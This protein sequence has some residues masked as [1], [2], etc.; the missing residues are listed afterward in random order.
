LK[1]PGVIQLPFAE[2]IFGVS[3]EEE[4]GFTRPNKTWCVSLTGLIAL[5]TISLI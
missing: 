5:I 3:T 4:Q 2:R 1:G